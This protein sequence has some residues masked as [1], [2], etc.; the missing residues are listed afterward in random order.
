MY[1]VLSTPAGYGPVGTQQRTMGERTSARGHAVTLQLRMNGSGMSSLSFPTRGMLIDR[2]AGAPGFEPGITGPKPDA[3]PLGHAPTLQ[4]RRPGA[5]APCILYR[6][7]MG[8]GN[9]HR[10]RHAAD[11][12]SSW[13]CRCNLVPGGLDPASGASPQ[14]TFQRQSGLEIPLN[15]NILRVF[16]MNEIS[17][18]EGAATA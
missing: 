11:F 5:T 9:R 8:R 6:R 14:Q 2:L 10:P 16:L 1:G 17:P 12:L 3:L 15:N 7:L 4:P 13:R 18:I